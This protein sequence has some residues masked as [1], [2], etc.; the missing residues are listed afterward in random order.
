MGTTSPFKDLWIKEYD[1]GF[2]MQTDEQCE[3]YVREN[4]ST[5]YH[6]LG[7]CALLP[8]EDGGV[9]DPELKVYGVRNLRVVDASVISIMISAN[10]QTAVYGIAERAAEIIA[11]EYC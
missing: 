10:I 4:V 7:T 9:V 6:P 11:A 5:F 2:A 1:P 8:K 3:A